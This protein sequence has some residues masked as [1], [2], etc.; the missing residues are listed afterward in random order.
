MD[1]TRVCAKNRN[2]SCTEQELVHRTGNFHAQNKSLCI[3]QEIFMHR[4]R[5]CSQYMQIDSLVKELYLFAPSGVCGITLCTDWDEPKDRSNP[6]DL[7]ASDRLE[8]CKLGWYANPIFGDGDYPQALKDRMPSIQKAFGL[9]NSPLPQFTE[10]EKRLNK[11]EVV[12]FE[13]MWSSG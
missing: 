4:T 8:H 13:D 3:E 6:S 12:Y 11:G 1:R 10:E 7:E 2:F 5:V 9:E